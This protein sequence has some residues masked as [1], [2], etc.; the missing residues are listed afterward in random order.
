MLQLAD[1]YCTTLTV[2]QNVAY[3]ALIR[4]PAS[5]PFNVKMAR[6]D[7]ILSELELGSIAD[8][9]V[10][11]ATGGGISGGQKRKLQLAIEM[12]S[13]P[14]MLFLDVKS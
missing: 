6:V 9:R 14:M 1:S 13:A 4:L 8:V 10:G 11:G 2:R 5:T 3:A 7:A 12:L